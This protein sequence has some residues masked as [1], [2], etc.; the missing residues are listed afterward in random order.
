V[1]QQKT[2]LN[3]MHHKMNAK[4]VD[5]AGWEMP[6]LFSS[7]L[8]EHNS[9]RNSS[10]IFDVSHMGQFFVKGK[11]SEIFLSKVTTWDFS[12]LSVGRCRYCHILRENGT[13]LDDTIVSRLDSDLFLLVPNASMI[14]SVLNHLNSYRAD[15][16][17]KITDRSNEY[18]CIALQGP[19]SPS[20]LKSLLDLDLQPFSVEIVDNIIISGTGYTGEIG[21]ELFIP[22]DASTDVWSKTLDL[23]AIPCGLASRDTLRLEKG[24]LLSGQD[25]NGSQTPLNTGHEWVIDWDHDFIGKN[26]LLEQKMQNYPVMKGILLE[27]RGIPR[28]DCEV[29]HNDKPVSQLTSGSLSPSL[30]KGIALAYLTQEIG[31]DVSIL[32]RNKH[33]K[34]KVVKPPFL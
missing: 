31:S 17:V 12:N 23:G 33:L 9:V 34:G 20:V 22:L 4:M 26:A 16:D 7:V 32:V 21:Y 8:E 2:A 29:Y 11:D 28:H 19:N 18:S 5:F 3:Q 13:I 6:I 30:G 14:E 10:G 27:D 24:M 1:S 15:L 25:F